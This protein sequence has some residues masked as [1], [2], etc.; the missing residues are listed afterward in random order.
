M[1]VVHV[2]NT[3]TSTSTGVMNIV[4][5]LVLFTLQHNI[6][7]KA[8]HIPTKLIKIADTISRSQWETFRNLSPEVEM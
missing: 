8:Q 6:T 2:I 1:A 3:L 5:K 7:N 4:R